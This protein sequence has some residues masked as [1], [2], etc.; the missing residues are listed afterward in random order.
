MTTTTRS[1]IK[2]AAGAPVARFLK[3]DLTIKCNDEGVAQQMRQ[4]IRHAQINKLISEYT[5]NALRSSIVLHDST[6]LSEEE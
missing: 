6:D 2:R 1:K 5:A 4:L 3:D